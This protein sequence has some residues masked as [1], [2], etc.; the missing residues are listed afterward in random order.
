MVVQALFAYSFA[1][2]VIV[3]VVNYFVV[4]SAHLFA[5]I[6]VGSV[7]DWFAALGTIGAVGLSLYLLR[8]E[9]LERRGAEARLV[10]IKRRL[11]HYG[12]PSEEDSVA[13]EE[14]NVVFSVYNNGSRPIFDLYVN[15]LIRDGFTEIDDPQFTMSELGPGERGEHESDFPMRRDNAEYLAR[16]LDADGR[17]WFRSLDRQKGLSSEE[18]WMRIN[19]AEYTEV[20]GPDPGWR[21]V[22]GQDSRGVR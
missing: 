16:F 9:Q 1:A 6:N 14:S 11:V 2:W 15:E 21:V 7:A 10:T 18:Y 13:L 3:Q 17:S 12:D 8:R 4:G 5:N 20:R 22:Y 19:N